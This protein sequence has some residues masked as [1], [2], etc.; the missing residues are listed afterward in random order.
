MVVVPGG[1]P[2]GRVASPRGLR[3]PMDTPRSRPS[4]DLAGR[5]CD[6]G[7]RDGGAGREVALPQ[8]P[9][10]VRASKMG[11]KRAIVLALVNVGMGL[12]LL[13]WYLA[14]MRTHEPR[15]LAPVEPSET[16]YTLEL[17]RIN[18]GFVFFVLAILSTWL[19]GRFICGWGCHI[20][21]LQDLCSWLLEKVRI[22]PKPFR[23]RLLVLMPAFMA[24]YMFVWPTFKRE[25]LRPVVSSVWGYDAYESLG[26]LI[27][28]TVPRPRF[29]QAFVVENLWET[30]AP[31]YVVIPFLI[32]CGFVTVYVL[33]AKGFCFY[34]CPYAGFFAPAD[35]LGIGRIKVNDNCHQCGHC[36]AVCTSNVRVHEEV[37]DYGMVVSSNC[38]KCMDCV[39]VCPKDAL[40]F[41]LGKPALFTPP[42]TPEARERVRQRNP[43][44]DLS[45]PEELTI[46]LLFYLLTFWGY[47]DLLYAVPLLMSAGLGAIVAFAIW[48][49]VR[50]PFSANLRFSHAQLK[51][52]GRLTRT[53]WIFVPCT[54]AL[55]ALGAWGIGVSF[56]RVAGDYWDYQVTAAQDEVLAPGYV[57]ETGQKAAA[58]HAIRCYTLADEPAHGGYGWELRPEDVSRM[59]WLYAVA[60]DRAACAKAQERVVEIVHRGAAEMNL[61]ATRAHRFSNVA[62]SVV[63]LGDFYALRDGNASAAEALLRS[64]SKDEPGLGQVKLALAGL[65]SQQGKVDS[66]CTL[67]EQAAPLDRRADEEFPLTAARAGELLARLGRPGPAEVLLRECLPLAHKPAAIDFALGHVLMGQGRKGEAIEAFSSAVKA[68]PRTPDHWRALAEARAQ[69][70]AKD[71]PLATLDEAVRARPRDASLRF[72]RAQV[73]GALDRI[74]EAQA[75]L[76]EGARLAPGDPRCHLA[77]AATQLQ[78]GKSK[79]AVATLR[80]ATHHRTRDAGLRVFLAQALEQDRQGEEAVRQATV[81]ISL[82]PHD[83]RVVPAAAE[84]LR[85]A[86][87]AA[88]AETALKALAPSKVTPR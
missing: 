13:Q 37:R 34:G 24:L 33:G 21:A 19:F 73:L 25:I 40:S 80:E 47:R 28:P 56:S 74:P 42:R 83:A 79:D 15:T 54:L 7:P 88:E 32:V 71:Q 75:D 38:M 55:L 31:W 39:S 66:A 10:K 9:S 86:G 44:Y 48:K 36:T 23:T 16:M 84:V 50:L 26:W 63:R 11:W 2:R 17:G 65:L 8:L 43:N 45:W 62:E 49:L 14:G 18:S 20:I 78:I 46:G 5:V 64:W 70:G 76:R 41:G 53:G 22:R 29:E 58:L 3:C 52:K 85:R 51:V 60:G 35:K 1:S 72:V 59:A 69:S 82:A 87:K 27:G 30:I 81:A 61:R 12:H 68:D 67:A 77:L 4:G 57:P 6:V